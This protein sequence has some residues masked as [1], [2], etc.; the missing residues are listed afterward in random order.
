MFKL[1][2]GTP[3][4]NAPEVDVKCAAAWDSSGAAVQWTV[5]DFQ[6]WFEHNVLLESLV[7]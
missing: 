7:G 1:P 5:I 6:D 4:L 3:A 2:Q